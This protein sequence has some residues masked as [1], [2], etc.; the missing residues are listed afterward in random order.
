[1]GTEAAGVA[2]DGEAAASARAAATS[3]Q[4]TIRAAGAFL[5]AAKGEHLLQA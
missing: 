1:M 4:A 2:A 5:G 3:P